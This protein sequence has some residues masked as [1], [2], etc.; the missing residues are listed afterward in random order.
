MEGP[1]STG[2][3]SWPGGMAAFL[4]SGL[5]RAALL[6]STTTRLQPA[7]EDA[8]DGIEVEVVPFGAIHPL[9][10]IPEPQ[11]V[12]PFSDKFGFGADGRWRRG[13]DGTVLIRFSRPVVF[14]FP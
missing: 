3:M 4:N 9:G 2:R 6:R 11:L 1:R 7:A 14:K 8:D 12:W 5:K 10:N 13:R